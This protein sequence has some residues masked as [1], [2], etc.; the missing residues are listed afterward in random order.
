MNQEEK[1]TEIGNFI[2]SEWKAGA[3]DA[4]GEMFKSALFQHFTE[5]YDNGWCPNTDSVN[6]SGDMLRNYVFVQ[7]FDSKDEKLINNFLGS[8]TTMWQEWQYALDNR[9]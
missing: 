7:I 4:C 3:T 5:A 8:I 1:F 9:K 2:I 6:I